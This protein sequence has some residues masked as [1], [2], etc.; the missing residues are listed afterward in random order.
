MPGPPGGYGP[1][2]PGP[3]YAPP[4]TPP[5]A[6][7][8]PYGPPAGSPGLSNG[9]KIALIIGAVALLLFCVCGVLTLWALA[10]AGHE[11]RDGLADP[12]RTR[13]A[14]TGEGPDQEQLPGQTYRRGECVTIDDTESGAKPRKVPCGPGT[15]EVLRSIP[16]TSNGDMCRLAEPDSDANV[17][18]DSPSNIEDFVLCLRSR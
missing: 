5:G 1:G 9:L 14:V 13:P 2:A 11:L 4:G 17:V 7:G 10:R 18:Y 8:A 12:W 16:F 15:Y 3:S 6:P